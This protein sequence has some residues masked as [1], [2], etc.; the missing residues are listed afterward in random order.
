MC[1]RLI[2]YYHAFVHHASCSLRFTKKESPLFSILKSY[3]PGYKSSSR[4]FTFSIPSPSDCS[5]SLLFTG[6]TLFSTVTCRVVFCAAMLMR[7][8]PFLETEFSPYLNAF[9]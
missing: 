9:S 8:K 3:L 7:T 4:L 2:V 5:A 6:G 1:Q